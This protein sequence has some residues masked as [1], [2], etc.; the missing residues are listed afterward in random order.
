MEEATCTWEWASLKFYT[1]YEVD[2]S[3][4][5]DQS[6]A[7]ESTA[8]VLVADALVRNLPRTYMYIHIHMYTRDRDQQYYC[9]S[10]NHQQG[11]TSPAMA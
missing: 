5:L 1:A 4:F 7:A 8:L 10:A 9:A 6:Q 3:R 2:L 11:K